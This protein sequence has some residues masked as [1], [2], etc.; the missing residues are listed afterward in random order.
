MYR[1]KIHQVLNIQILGKIQS[2]LL[3]LEICKSSPQEVGNSIHSL[4]ICNVKRGI[5]VNLGLSN[6][7]LFIFVLFEFRPGPGKGTDME[8][9]GL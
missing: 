4:Q 6:I 5:E 9:V 3:F 1:V 8:L 2:I 7:Y